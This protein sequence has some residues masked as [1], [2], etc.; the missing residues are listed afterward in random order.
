[1]NFAGC[2]NRRNCAAGVAENPT[3]SH[4][5]WFIDV[6]QRRGDSENAPAKLLLE[7]FI[8]RIDKDMFAGWDRHVAGTANKPSIQAGCARSIEFAQ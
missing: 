7:H 4:R 3:S 6:L 1:M 2:E 5:K 8:E